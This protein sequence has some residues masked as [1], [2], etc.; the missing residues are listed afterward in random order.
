[1]QGIANA[2]ICGT[3]AIRAVG[4]CDEQG[5][6][7]LGL[8]QVTGR[9]WVKPSNVAHRRQ[10]GGTLGFSGR[11]PNC[12]NVL[13]FLSRRCFRKTGRCRFYAALYKTTSSN[14]GTAWV[15]DH[16]RTLRQTA[17]RTRVL[18]HL[19]RLLAFGAFLCGCFMWNEHGC[20]V[21][22]LV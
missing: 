16:S 7:C 19:Q 18:E 8:E 3:S 6:R 10:V 11:M 1:M 22:V 14:N 5:C 17:C 4:R 9:A 13:P 21:R 12:G 20:R 15:R 2:S